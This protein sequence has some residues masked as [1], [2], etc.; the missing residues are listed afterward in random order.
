MG[1]AKRWPV[2]LATAAIQRHS[3]NP[4]WGQLVM[5]KSGSVSSG[6][7]RV[8]LCRS[9][10]CRLELWRRL[11]FFPLPRPFLAIGST[12]SM[13]VVF[14]ALSLAGYGVKITLT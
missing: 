2:P 3:G 4:V 8:F 12:Y 5:T 10:S 11:P 6:G 13:L 9:C 7:V 1:C 14:K